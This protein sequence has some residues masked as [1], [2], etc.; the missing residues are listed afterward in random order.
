MSKVFYDKYQMACSFWQDGV[1]F[2]NS[3]R[4]VF[5]PYGCLD[6]LNMSLLGIIQA[7]SRAQVC[8]FAVKREDK[9]ELKALVKDAQQRMKDAARAEP[10]VLELSELPVDSSLPAEEQLKQYKS[11][12]V[13]GVLTKEQFS[14]QKKLLA[15][16]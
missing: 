14:F 4:E 3:K 6:S 2:C 8:C 5:Y 16:A 9:A 13:Q 7:K 15:E 12:Y 1:A 11:L 10:V